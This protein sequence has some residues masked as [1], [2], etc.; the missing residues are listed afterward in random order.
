[1]PKGDLHKLSF[2]HVHFPLAV[3]ILKS[4][5]QPQT[6]EATVVDSFLTEARINSSE[7][8]IGCNVRDRE[9]PARCLIYI[10]S[11]RTE[12]REVQISRRT[13]RVVEYVIKI[14]AHF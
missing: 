8:F 14:G 12:L 2:L 3:S 9:E 5:S 10:K 13:K 6:D 4:Q 1:M 11:K 7:V